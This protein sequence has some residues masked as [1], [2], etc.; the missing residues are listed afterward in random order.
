M[1]TFS[2]IAFFMIRL[3][4]NQYIARTFIRSLYVKVCSSPYSVKYKVSDFL[5]K[6]APN[7]VTDKSQL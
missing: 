3:T 6:M 1:T 4:F 2:T 5:F 7:T